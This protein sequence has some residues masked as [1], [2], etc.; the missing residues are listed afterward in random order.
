MPGSSI[1]RISVKCPS[2]AVNPCAASIRF[3]GN[4]RT[5]AII[6]YFPILVGNS[7]IRNPGQW[8]GW[9]LSI[10]GFTDK[11]SFMTPSFRRLIIWPI[12]FGFRP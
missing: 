9:N 11:L 3:R 10:A 8:L 12:R 2:N 6:P 1:D 4:P 7:E 5:R